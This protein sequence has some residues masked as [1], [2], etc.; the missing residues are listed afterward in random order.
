MLL[1]RESQL[2]LSFDLFLSF[3]QRLFIFFCIYVRL[4]GIIAAQWN[5]YQSNDNECCAQ[6]P[7]TRNCFTKNPATNHRLQWNWQI[8]L[9]KI[10]F[11]EIRNKMIPSVGIFAT[12]ACFLAQKLLRIPNNSNWL[13]CWSLWPQLIRL[14]DEALSQRTSTR[15]HCKEPLNRCKLPSTTISRIIPA[16]NQI[17]SLEFFYQIY[18]VIDSYEGNAYRLTRI[19]GDVVN[20]FIRI[21][22]EFAK[23]AGCRSKQTR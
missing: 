4:I 6:P 7:N 12:V 10:N 17:I 22:Y 14:V 2:R 9:V 16:K 19:N 18:A 1:K 3:D 20:K 13:R 5:E 8:I 15:T 21:W 11:H 23:N